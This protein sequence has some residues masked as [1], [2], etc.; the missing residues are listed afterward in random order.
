LAEYG[1]KED[2][3]AE[4]TVREER[5]LAWPNAQNVKALLPDDGE[6]SMVL[7]GEVEKASATPAAGTWEAGMMAK[8]ME[9]GVTRHP[10]RAMQDAHAQVHASFQARSLTRSTAFLCLES[11]AQEQALLKK[12]AEVLNGSALFDAGDEL[13]SMSEPAEWIALLIIAFIAL[14][15][16]L[17]PK[18]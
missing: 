16:F 17:L 18:R 12:Q 1:V 13:E 10:D 15:R 8:A 11:E 4:H 5:W 2:T 14:I 7:T 3:Q 9:E 6:P